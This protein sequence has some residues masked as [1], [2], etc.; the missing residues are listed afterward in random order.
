MLSVSVLLKHTSAGHEIKYKD[1]EVLFGLPL[2]AIIGKP[3]LSNLL[4]WLKANRRSDVNFKLANQ[5]YTELALQKIYAFWPQLVVSVASADDKHQPVAP[6]NQHSDNHSIDI[7]RKNDE[8]STFKRDGEEGSIDHINYLKHLTMVP[9]IC[10]VQ[11]IWLDRHS[12]NRLFRDPDSF[13]PN[14][15]FI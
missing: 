1:L 8:I 11:L 13:Q 7:Q 12:T 15:N 4:Q 2:A 9:A 5:T 10:K 14:V 3:A 6:S